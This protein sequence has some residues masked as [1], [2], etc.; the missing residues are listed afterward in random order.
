MFFLWCD[1]KEVA[2]HTHWTSLMKLWK[3]MTR[4]YRQSQFV[5][6]LVKAGSRPG[7]GAASN[8]TCQPTTH[9]TEMHIK[10][11]H[12]L[13]LSISGMKKTGMSR[14]MARMIRLSCPS[15][16]N[17]HFV[18]SGLLWHFSYVGGY[19]ATAPAQ[20]D[21]T[22]CSDTNLLFLAGGLLWH[23]TRHHITYQSRQREK[24]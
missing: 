16:R 21:R 4:D 5:Q 14:C 13:Y 1:I 15:P 24:W 2:L 19:L 22:T 12:V 10:C 3:M 8:C 17:H 23:I 11:A 9:R 20:L 18:P 6:V 7:R